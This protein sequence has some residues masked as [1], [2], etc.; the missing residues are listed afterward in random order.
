[1]KQS[2]AITE[3]QAGPIS[4]P[5]PALIRAEQ[6]RLAYSH[7]PLA[8]LATVMNA[9]VLT[10]L[11]WRH[12][13][14]AALLTWLSLAL[15]LS[16]TRY[17]H[18]LSYRRQT[19]TVAISENRFR[20]GALAAGML[21]SSIPIFLFPTGAF[22]YQAMMTVVL[23]GMGA[24]AA[25]T[26]SSHR[27]VLQ[28]V[29]MLML[30]PLIVRLAMEG[31]TLPLVMSG[32][33]ALFLVMISAAASMFHRNAMD[34][35]RL[36][37]E[38]QQREQA[39]KQAE[40]QYRHLFEMANDAILIVDPEGIIFNA[41]PVSYMRLGYQRQE[42]LG[43]NIA[44][45]LSPKFAA[46]RQARVRRIQELG[47]LS[48]ESE[49]VCKDG[50]LMPVEVN[51][52]LIDYRGQKAVLSIVRDITER[53][54]AE[55]RLRTLS[56]ALEQAGESVIIT[57]HDG[58]IEYTNPAFTAITGYTPEEVWGKDLHLL[59]MSHGRQQASLY[60]EMWKTVRA[61]KVWQKELT[62]RRKDGQQASMFMS[63]API[64]DDD[65]RMSHFVGTQ[66]DITE[67]VELEERLRQA[68]KMEAIGTLVGGIAHDFNNVLAGVTGNLFLAKQQTQHLPEVTEK[69]DLSEKLAFSASRMVQQLLTFARKGVVE[70]IPMD[71]GRFMQE[72][73][74]LYELSIPDNIAY[75]GVFCEQELPVRGDDTQLQQMI[76]NL[77]NN[78]RDAL[79]GVEN[80][81][82][83]L[84]L[85]SFDA[86]P[87]F[88]RRHN[89]TTRHFARISIEDNGCGIPDDIKARIFEPFFTTKEIGSGTG[90]GLA[91]AYGTITSHDGLIDVESTPGTGTA[92][93]IYLPLQPH[94]ELQPSV[95]SDTESPVTGRGETLLVVDDDPQIREI[96]RHILEALDYRVLT[97]SD[98]MEAIKVFN[99]NA[100]DI[101]LIIMDLV[102]P[103]LGGALAYE[104][105]HRSHEDVRVIFITSHDLK[106]RLEIAPHQAEAVVLQKPWSAT[107]LSQS[108]RTAL[109]RTLH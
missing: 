104:Q 96:T 86:S 83:T 81:H 42:I 41:N 79:T 28:T 63:F 59:K 2:A 102:M 64:I 76:V 20:Y 84:T 44:C 98:G 39:L 25:V 91:M 47:S 93:R 57:G 30:T 54:Q 3:P 35:I 50:R 90:L 60:R 14:H 40:D 82:I 43:M 53:K 17:M 7:L 49:H 88:R 46:S 32:L 109:D 94:L 23:A 103:R 13:G 67:H 80:P 18:T 106:Q 78:A 74:R 37:L 61:G 10:A 38:A 33:S 101:K 52:Q 105:L 71:L 75:R 31:K 56:R 34:S 55:D 92:F 11:L 73:N 62:S 97:A 69:L 70:I 1:M 15:L 65:G 99:R 48:F 66:Q 19:D 4:P 51:A 89:T 58:L 108:V 85:E 29:L 95:T 24:G 45:L 68:Q 36:G 5:L 100:D 77:L 72:T 6:V 21:W 12:V 16:T 107:Q 27:E 26:L 9:L 8:L 87:E 22:S